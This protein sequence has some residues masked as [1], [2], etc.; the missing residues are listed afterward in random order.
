MSG[1]LFGT[2]FFNLLKI[3]TF[4]PS[5]FPIRQH[6]HAPPYRTGGIE[7][8]TAGIHPWMLGVRQFAAALG[9]L[10]GACRP[11]AKR[12]S[13]GFAD[14]GGAAAPPSAPSWT[15]ARPATA[16][17][18]ALRKGLRAADARTGRPRA[19]AGRHLPRI[20]R[21]GEQAR[22]ALGERLLP[23]SFGVRTFASPKTLEALRE[24]PPGGSSSSKPTTATP[25]EEV[26]AHAA[27]VKR[28]RGCTVEALKRTTTENY[29]R[30]FL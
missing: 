6:T 17:R 23:L 4:A 2:G 19:P 18:A 13:I 11:S 12:G 15:G 24:T 10:G 28:W 3:C 5:C 14:P 9:A 25:I 16:R 21:I 30:I 7:L 22:R 27:E 20:H 1:R 29:E 26:Y 8:R